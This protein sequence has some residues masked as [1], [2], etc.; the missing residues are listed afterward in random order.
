[1]GN[2]LKYRIS[3]INIYLG[4]ICMF[5][6]VTALMN[7][8]DWNKLLFAILCS[9]HIGILLMKRIKLRTVLLL[10]VLFVHYVFV[11]FQTIFPLDN[12]NL[13]FYYPFF[14][15]YTFFM[16]DHF[17]TI[18]NW[19]FKHKKHIEII[20][21]LW[22]VL[23]GIS[24][25]LP[26]SY[27]SDMGGKIF[28]GSYCG[29]I[30]RLGP[31]AVFI[32]VLVLILQSM[33]RNSKGIFWMIIP[34]YSYLMGS[35][36]TYLVIGFC[37]LVI[38]WYM[39]CKKKSLFWGTVVPLSL[40][41]LWLVTVSAMGDKLEYTMDETRYGDFWYRISSSRS[42]IWAECIDA[43]SQTN[44]QG[45]IFGNGLGFTFEMA[46][47]WA[48]ND[49]IEILCSFGVLG[50]VQYCTAMTRLI[51]KAYNQIRIPFFIKVCIFMTWFFNA[52]FNMHYVYFCAMLS[53]PF[54]LMAVR[55]YFIHNP[56]ETKWNTQDDAELQKRKMT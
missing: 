8:G 42:V 26:S 55:C 14:L 39:V 43:W 34:M 54:L 20:I 36:R 52:F 33:H 9:V 50:L 17:D 1:M 27:Y 10:L 53:F 2:S 18:Y 37:L 21:I 22:S 13:L 49:Y 6:I 5:P 56:K 4:I 45:K 44:I 16:T 12:T 11:L 15:V 31:S 47:H 32:Q 30:F 28:F 19:F 24:I 51:R 38:S 48:H 29:S 46:K 3:L 25:F 7:G 41:I 40:L 23:V 35:S